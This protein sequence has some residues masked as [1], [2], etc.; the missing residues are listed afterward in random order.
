MKVKEEADY[1]FMTKNCC[2]Y[3]KVKEEADYIFMTKN[4]CLFLLQVDN[5]NAFGKGMN[6]TI[7]NIYSYR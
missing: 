5:T 2:L 1:I 3:L 6:L 4:C 7:L